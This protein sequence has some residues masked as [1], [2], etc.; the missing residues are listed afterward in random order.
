M[1]TRFMNGFK[2]GLLMLNMSPERLIRPTSSLKKCA[3]APIF[4]VLGTSSCPDFL[5]FLMTPFWRFITHPSAH[6]KWY[7]RRLHGS[8]YRAALLDIFPP[9]SPLQYSAAFPIFHTYAV[10]VDTFSIGV[11]VLLPLI[12]SETSLFWFPPEIT[13]RESTFSFLLSWMHG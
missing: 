5:H 8:A 9:S 6:R 2:I 12:F 3:M 10:P 1:K 7:L 11:T 4:V 13:S